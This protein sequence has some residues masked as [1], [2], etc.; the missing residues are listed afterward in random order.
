MSEMTWYKDGKTL[1]RAGRNCRIFENM[2]NLLDD[3]D[4]KEREMVHGTRLM[5]NGKCQMALTESSVFVR[6]TFKLKVKKV[7]H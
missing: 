3:G 4:K 6:S 2:R 7:T 1:R 5:A